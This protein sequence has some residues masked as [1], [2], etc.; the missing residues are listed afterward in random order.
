MNFADVLRPSRH[1][2]RTEKKHVAGQ[3]N[4][5][6]KEKHSH[7]HGLTLISRNGGKSDADRQMR[8]NE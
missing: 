3:Q 4:V 7:L 5:R 2:T 1:L 6:Q 8:H